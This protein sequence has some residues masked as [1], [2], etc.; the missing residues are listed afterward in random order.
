MQTDA[1]INSE[2]RGPDTEDPPEDMEVEMPIEM[3]A[4]S[5]IVES[6]P[7]SPIVEQIPKSAEKMVSSPEVGKD[8]L[9]A[10]M[11]EQTEKSAEKEVVTAST[12]SSEQAKVEVD[13]QVAADSAESQETVLETQVLRLH[14]Q[15][16]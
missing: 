14:L 10:G 16:F 11:I 5:P 12:P 15:G 13:S 3:V 9:Q 1:L 6:K 7:Q 8:S 2:E 4:K